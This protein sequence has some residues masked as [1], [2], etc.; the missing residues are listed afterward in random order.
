MGEWKWQRNKSQAPM[1]TPEE[2][3]FADCWGKRPI[4]LLERLQSFQGLFEVRI[5][6]SRKIKI[7]RKLGAAADCKKQ[8]W[9]HTVLEL[10]TGECP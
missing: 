1:L 7:T 2:Q 9:A 10:H 6:R 4:L 8:E 3:S 5:E